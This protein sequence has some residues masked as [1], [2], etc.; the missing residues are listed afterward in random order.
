MYGALGGRP[1][2]DLGTLGVFPECPGAFVS[3]QICWPAEVECLPTSTEVLS[4]WNSWL[5]SWL[6]QESFDGVVTIRFRKA[7]GGEFELRL[8]RK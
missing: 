2:L 7:D 3:V 1:G 6:D 8:D 5:D 4:C